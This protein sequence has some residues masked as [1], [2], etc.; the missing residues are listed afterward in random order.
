[1]RKKIL[2]VLAT[3]A[4]LAGTVPA[5]AQMF[6]HDSEVDRLVR[7]NQRMV[8]RFS[9]GGYGYHDHYYSRRRHHNNDGVWL[10]LGLGAVAGALVY[11]ALSN[12]DQNQTAPPPPSYDNS[13]PREEN[14]WNS[15]LREQGGQSLWSRRKCDGFRLKNETG[16]TIR[17]YK[18]DE[19][20]VIVRPGRAG[21]GDPFAEY[22][23]EV[24]AAVSDG[25]TARA[26]IVRAKPEGQS[27]G[28]WVWR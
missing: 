28:V 1:M 14:G 26:H 23:A 11:G 21:C 17:V 13:V 9:Y 10:G 24:V 7:S 20:Y 5:H 2:S 4:L 16:E 8:N 3:V 27:G 12:R 19:P 25:Y 22:T 18:D 15:R 6:G